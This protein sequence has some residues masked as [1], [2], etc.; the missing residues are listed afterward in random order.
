M[1]WLNI[2]ESYV[3]ISWIWDVSELI[4]NCEKKMW[5]AIEAERQYD[6]RSLVTVHILYFR[7]IHPQGGFIG[8]LF[9]N[10]KNGSIYQKIYNMN[11]LDTY[12]VVNSESRIEK[13]INED[14]MALI[15]SDSIFKKYNKYECKVMQICVSSNI[16]RIFIC[17]HPLVLNY[18]LCAN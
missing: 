1:I 14:K 13:L 4:S 10:G 9:V 18:T 5:K 15:A 11:Q 17:Q 12:T 8:E 2:E 16:N 6:L 3:L 7:V